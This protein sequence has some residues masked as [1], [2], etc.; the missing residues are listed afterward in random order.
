MGCDIH[1]FNEVRR[2]GKWIMTG[3][4]R[5]SRHYDLFGALAG[6]RMPHLAHIP[7]RGLPDD[8]SNGV[9]EMSDLYGFDGHSHTYLSLKEVAR[10]IAQ[11]TDDPDKYECGTIWGKDSLL[12]VM[13]ER[14]EVYGDD[15][16]SNVRAVFWFDN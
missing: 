6:V 12:S 8:V 2:D 16:S 1:W 11:V 3:E 10:A 15:D 13:R 7:P 5:V 9:K 4:V 14:A